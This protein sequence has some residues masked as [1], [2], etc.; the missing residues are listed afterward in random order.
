VRAGDAAAGA[1]AFGE[2]LE[3]YEQALA[4]WDQLADADALAGIDRIELLRRAG[5]VADLASARL[6]AVAFLREALKD[7][8]VTLFDMHRSTAYDPIRR[9]PDFVAIATPRG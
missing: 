6:Q 4:V 3:Q 7:G 8:A 9:R 5:H 1:F 2:A